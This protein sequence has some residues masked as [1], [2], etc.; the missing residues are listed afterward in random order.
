[1]HSKGAKGTGPPHVK[2]SY[3]GAPVRTPAR[4]IVTRGV[5]SLGIALALGLLLTAEF[6]RAGEWVQVSCENPNG[7]PASS[8]GWTGSALGSPPP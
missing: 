1:V 2:D 8:Q 6:A 3:T 5:L 4:S 7:T